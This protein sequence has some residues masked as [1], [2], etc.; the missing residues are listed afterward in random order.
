MGQKKDSEI[1]LFKGAVVVMLLAL[2]GL[3]IIQYYWMN[4]ITNLRKS[5][6]T[7]NIFMAFNES[8]NEI[9][10]SRY[11][12]N[13]DVPMPELLDVPVEEMVRYKELVD[14]T[15]NYYLTL[16]GVDVTYYWAVVERGSTEI[17]MGNHNQ[18]EGTDLRSVQV[19]RASPIYY[20]MPYELVVRFADSSWQTPSVIFYTMG[21]SL[22][23]MVV[24]IVGTILNL[25]LHLKRQRELDFWMDFIG[26]MVHEFK[27]PMSSI[28]LASELIMK[29]NVIH[30]PGRVVQYSSLI[31]RE[32]SHLK[33]M[34]DK[35]LRAIS[36]DMGVLTLKLSEVD[37]HQEIMYLTEPFS[38]KAEEKGGVLTLNL[39]ATDYV[40]NI[41]KMHVLNAITNLLDNAIKYTDEKPDIVVETRSDSEGI[42]I[43]VTDNG[44]GIPQESLNK[45]FDKFY[46]VRSARSYSD[47]GYGLGL[48]YVAYIMHAHKGTVHVTSKMD[49]GSS[50]ELFFPH[51][52]ET[53]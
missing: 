36:L 29:T 24:L 46:R 12:E 16:A 19:F 39:D 3:L 14:N 8:V 45:L 27:T 32:N 53:K 15:L 38:L 43:K 4:A 52:T 6:V 25:R 21:V 10:L 40:L 5:I 50:F 37:I 17:V 44:I 33:Q 2:V 9:M 31:Y 18:Y 35:L 47:S 26:N 20:Q 34:I 28:S 49:K 7:E 23:C 1:S 42:Y 48:F 51:F 22:S 41:D 11:E 13:E 30:D